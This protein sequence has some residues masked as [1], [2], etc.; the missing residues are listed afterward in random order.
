MRKHTPYLCSLSFPIV[1]AIAA[2]IVLVGQLTVWATSAYQV[3]NPS[4]VFCTDSEQTYTCSELVVEP[5][6]CLLALEAFERKQF[7]DGAVSS[8]SGSTMEEEADCSREKY[9][10]YNAQEEK[11]ES[12]TWG[13]WHQGDKTVTGNNECP[14]E[15]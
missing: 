2:S 14:T 12:G 8:P 15:E 13:S 6:E 9:C 11:C 7:P 5:E 4:T 3:P 10:T 1:G